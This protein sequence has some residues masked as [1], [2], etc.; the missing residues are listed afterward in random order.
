MS[1]KPCVSVFVASYNNASFI[2][3]SLESV[4]LQSYDN[5]ELIIIDDA[6]SDNSVQVINNWI[7]E[8]NYNCKFIINETNK[9]VCG[10]SNIFLDN[11]TGDYIS[12]LAS[13][14]IMMPEKLQR[15]ID[16]FNGSPVDVGVVYSDAYIINENGKRYFSKFIQ[17]HRQFVDIPEGFIMLE[18]LLGNFIPVMTAL[19]KKECF[20]NCGRYDEQLIYEDYDMFLRISRKYKFVFSDYKAAEYRMHSNNFHKKLISVRA[21][22][23]SFLILSKHIG[24]S[25]EYDLIIRSRLVGY[26]DQMREVNS[27]NLNYYLSKFIKFFGSTK[28]MRIAMRY[29]ISYSKVVLAHRVAML[30]KKIILGA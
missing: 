29:S 17:W 9:G 23:T 16:V 13:D 2:R 27:P 1:K 12:W 18:L 26:I 11:V 21:L 30:L 25:K 4:R 19:F 20:D 22:E 6:S 3:Q 10:V 15:Q 14:D 5:I 24:L 28:S 8:T 7:S